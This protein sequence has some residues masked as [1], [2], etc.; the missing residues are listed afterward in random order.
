VEQAP[1]TEARPQS[2]KG[3]HGKKPTIQVKQDQLNFMGIVSTQEHL[4]LWLAIIYCFMS[5]PSWTSDAETLDPSLHLCWFL[6]IKSEM[7]VNEFG[8]YCLLAFLFFI[9]I[10]FGNHFFNL[11]SLRLISKLS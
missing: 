7:L 11:V 5:N 3:P 10:S 6:K 4:P 1:S 2:N 8:K 9:E